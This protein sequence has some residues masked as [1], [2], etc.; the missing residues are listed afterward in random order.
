MDSGILTGIIT[1]AVLGTVFILLYISS[2]KHK[3]KKKRK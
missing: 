2:K 3:S 1:A